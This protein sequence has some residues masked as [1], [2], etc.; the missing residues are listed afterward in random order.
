MSRLP[1]F[2]LGTV[3][4]PGG[5]LPLRIF[6]KRYVLLLRELLDHPEREREFGV[7][8]IRSGQEVG[9]G[10]ATD[11]FGIGCTARIYHV[12]A[13]GDGTFNVLTRGMRRFRLDG[14]EDDAGTPY[15]TGRITWLEDPAIDARALAP[16]AERVLAE[17]ARYRSLFPT[18]SA[19]VPTEPEDLSYRL[20][21]LMV[22]DNADRHQ[23]LACPDTA[24]RLEL[25]RR[26]LRREF[27]LVGTLS[28]VPH[29]GSFEPG[30]EN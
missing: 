26:L 21:D 16:L 29:H 10:Q 17:L 3:L 18:Q 24:S 13:L 25:G 20:A 30:P 28:A 19:A 1:I 5:R 6:E 8:G 7:V 9:P 27:V 4:V 23:L 11:L 15:L 2:P 22:L 14:F 12:D